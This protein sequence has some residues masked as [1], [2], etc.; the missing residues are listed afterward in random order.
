MANHSNNY[1]NPDQVRDVLLA[2]GREPVSQTAQRLGR[3]KQSIINIQYG[4]AFAELH[5][6]LP[7]KQRRRNPLPGESSCRIC[8]H[9][10]EEPKPGQPAC[11]LGLPDAREVGFG[12][13][14]ECNLYRLRR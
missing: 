12:F 6:E 10:I 14:A 7:R 5:P 2:I 11:D 3:T 8:Q 13:A 4:K 9:W 1:L